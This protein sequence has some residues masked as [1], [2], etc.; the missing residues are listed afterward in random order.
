MLLDQSN[1]VILDITSQSFAETLKRATPTVVVVS[2]LLMNSTAGDDVTLISM[3][4][5]GFR[6]FHDMSCK[7]NC[8]A[9]LKT[10]DELHSRWWRYIDINECYGLQR[11]PWHVVQD[12]LWCLFE[13]CWWTPQQ[14]MTLHWY[15]WVLWASEDSMTCRA[16]PTVVLVW[17]L[18]MNST[19][20]YDV[21][22]ISMSVMGF[23]LSFVCELFSKV[24][25]VFCLV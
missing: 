16:T 18:L 23:S 24:N 3:S 5:M 4:V 15:Q 11:I 22:L 13:D 9:C 7:T 1:Y 25:V 17:R 21:T 6:G 2:R 14:V 10:V 19:A 20:G 12:Q 8:G